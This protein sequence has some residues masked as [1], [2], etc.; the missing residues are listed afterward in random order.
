VAP[1]CCQQLFAHLHGG[2]GLFEKGATRFV[3][4]AYLNERYKPHAPAGETRVVDL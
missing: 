1:K 3:N 4:A 2:A